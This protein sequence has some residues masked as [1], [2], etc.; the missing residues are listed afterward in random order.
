MSTPA[1]GAPVAGVL[2][3]AVAGA[4]G[5]WWGWRWAIGLGV[6]VAV[7]TALLFGVIVRPTPPARPDVPIWE[8]VR[9]HRLLRVLARPRIALTLGLSACGAFVWQG[10]AS[11]LPTFLMAYHGYSDPAA[12]GLFSLY[13]GV[14]GLVQPA[15]GSLSDRIGR[16]PAAAL[17]LAVGVGGYTAL[18]FGAAGWVVVGGVV[19]AGMAMS[20]GAA[21]LPAF[22]DHLGREERSAG[23]GL[24]RTTYMVLGAGGSVAT[25]AAADL[26]GW[27]VAFL[28]L[29]V[30]QVGMLGV[31]IYAGRATEPAGAAAPSR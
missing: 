1:T 2:I 7:P 16:Y 8:R 18:V 22:M 23:F 29:A 30:L 10:T 20:W 5:A 25:G 24:A 26:V 27:G 9:G 28:G 4:I 17:A 13:F 31:L 6:L 15:L 3:P 12:G 14:Q 19:G 11:F 21:L